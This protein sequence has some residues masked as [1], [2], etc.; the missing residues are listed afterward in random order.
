VRTV[1]VASGA[2]AV[3]IVHSSR[4]G[5]RDIERIGSAHDDAELE[6][7]KAVTRQRWR[8]C[9]VNSTWA[10]NLP[11]VLAELCSFRVRRSQ[12]RQR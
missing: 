11:A 8:I 4:R 5:S 10:W 12:S 3:Q 2:R 6:L 7:F 9:R 1:K